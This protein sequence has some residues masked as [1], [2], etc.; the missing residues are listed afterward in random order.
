MARILLIEP[1]KLLGRTYA[2][3]LQ[4]VGHNVILTDS[5]QAAVNAADCGSPDIV[6]MELQ[7]VGHNGIEFLYEFRTYSEWQQIPVL[8]HS[9]VPPT[10][11]STN[12]VLWG[13]LSASAYLYKPRTSLQQLIRAVNLYALSAGQLAA[14]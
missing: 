5:A 9:L 8:I 2:T 6:V 10:E 14:A 7:L 13:E 11:F 1:N 3:A 12:L 4:H